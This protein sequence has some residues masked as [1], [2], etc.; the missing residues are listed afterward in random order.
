MPLGKASELKNIRAEDEGG[1]ILLALPFPGIFDDRL[2][3][4]GKSGAFEEQGTDLAAELAHRPVRME[5]ARFP[6]KGASLNLG[7]TVSRI[8]G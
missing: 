6:I 5:A 1:E 8:C 4:S 7:D 2:L 3:V